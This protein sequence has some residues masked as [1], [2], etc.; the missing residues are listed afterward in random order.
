MTTPI[1]NIQYFEKLLVN[2]QVRK[3]ESNYWQM[4]S[5]TAYGAKYHIPNED[6][7]ETFIERYEL[8]IH[9]VNE[10]KKRSD[11]YDKHY[12]SLVRKSPKI[13]P[14]IIDVDLRSGD[15]VIVDDLDVVY[16]D[17]PVPRLAT[18]DIIIGVCTEY[19]NIIQSMYKDKFN[20][21]FIYVCERNHA[22]IDKKRNRIKDGLHITIPK[23]IVDVDTLNHITDS[24]T[25][26]LEKDILSEYRNA[27]DKA[28]N[29]GTGWM[30]YGS[31]KDGK[32]HYSLTRKFKI[33]DMSEVEITDNP[34][35][36]PSILSIHGHK[37][38]SYIED[39]RVRRI[40][41][42]KQS[43]L[44]NIE[45]NQI[46][47]GDINN[48]YTEDHVKMYQRILQNLSIRRVQVRDDWSK[49]GFCLATGSNKDNR[50]LKLFDEFSQRS[51]NHYDSDGVIKLWTSASN[52]GTR[53]REYSLATLFRW[54]HI[55][56]IGSVTSEFGRKRGK[57]LY[58]EIANM[59][60]V[61]RIRKHSEQWS[62]TDISN[63][64]YDR[65]KNEY[66][67]IINGKATD[68]Y[69][70]ENHI[71]RPIFHTADLHAYIENTLIDLFRQARDKEI[72]SIKKSVDTGQQSAKRHDSF[73]YKNL[74]NTLFNLGTVSRRENYIKSFSHKIRDDWFGQKINQKLHLFAFENGVYDFHAGEF[75]DG[76]P[77]DFITIQAPS[78]YRGGGSPEYFKKI[79][80]E[81]ARR[82]KKMKFG[83]IDPE[84]GVLYDDPYKLWCQ[85][86]TFF[87]E[88]FPLPELKHYV[89][90]ELSKCL[91]GNRV[92]N[93][94]YICQGEGGNGKSKFFLLLS[95]AFGCGQ[96]Y[97]KVDI[98][99]FTK[100]R[101]NPSSASPQWGDF[102]FPRII[103]TSEPDTDVQF[104]T[105][106]IRETTGGDELKYRNLYSGT[107]I[108]FT[109]QSRIFVHVNNPPRLKEVG[110]SIARRLRF[111]PFM[112][113]FIT[114]DEDIV[115]ARKINNYV[116]RQDV[117][118]DR[119]ISSWAKSGVFLS[120][121]VHHYET[122]IKGKQIHIP[123]IVV[124][125]TKQYIKDNN[126][127]LEFINDLLTVSSD[128]NSS[129][130][131][132]QL[133]ERFIGYMKRRELKPNTNRAILM[134][135]I[136]RQVGQQHL[137]TKGTLI[138]YEFKQAM[139]VFD[140][141]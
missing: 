19:A 63:L 119:K 23:V 76:L 25:D 131:P 101:G 71:W 3:G 94:L 100:K 35:Y 124:E 40:L 56:L 61:N 89:I 133:Y 22:S 58:N 31:S 105:G 109:P 54:L 132:S 32:V 116:K 70:F 66:K 33:G 117:D 37:G 67:S 139:P 81:N 83:E 79:S 6:Y 134:K 77:N 112:A 85:I 110:D 99:I 39:E 86:D 108:T 102:R 126:Y 128:M 52:Q 59:D 90:G 95:S 43:K 120:Y 141:I 15:D 87:S 130:K 69:K 113:K 88:V 62:D 93:V 36:L 91:T 27:I 8:A 92:E 30:L 47:L 80:E 10:L 48:K 11:K 4:P 53:E 106:I 60:I 42:L 34:L 97:N 17:K 115:A 65:L 20:D 121:L 75:R 38:S 64:M 125:Y 98:S 111:I 74:R 122:Y 14:I 46:L 1:E 2:L 107:M 7:E 129:I 50:F 104:N 140:S 78:I 123:P 45:L 28:V 12:Y 24:V 49:V 55:D 127:V 138:G 18:N 96:Y 84:D 114:E 21:S 136:I 5:T 44:K 29:S 135:N 26:V 73:I 41:S 82:S 9:A 72:D 51:P 103:V 137:S 68:Y 16:K 118:I 57:D 13:K